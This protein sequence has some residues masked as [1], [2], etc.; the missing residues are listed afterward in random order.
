MIRFNLFYPNRLLQLAISIVLS[1]Y[2]ENCGSKAVKT[3]KA[4]DLERYKNA[5]NRDG[6][7]SQIMYGMKEPPLYAA[8]REG[9]AEKVGILLK[10]IKADFT[11]S[12]EEK[13]DLNYQDTNFPNSVDKASGDTALLKAIRN[14]QEKIA[15][16]LINCVHFKK[17][18]TIANENNKT[19]TPLRLAIANKLDNAAILLIGKLAESNLGVLTQAKSTQDRETPLHLAVKVK[20]HTIAD[21]LID[22][23][24][25]GD[26][27]AIDNKGQTA[28]HIAI[29]HKLTEIVKKLIQRQATESLYIADAEQNT[30]LH[31]AIQRK[32]ETMA[33]TL[34]EKLVKAQA[35]ES[36]YIADA[37]QNTPLHIAIQRKLTNVA[38]LLIDHINA[39][40]LVLV[41]NDKNNKMMPLH[42]AIEKGEYE[43]VK[44]LV[45]KVADNCREKLTTCD[46]KDRNPL[47]MAA[48]YNDIASFESIWNEV[49]KL[50]NPT[51][52]LIKK[53]HRDATVFARA[54]LPKN[55]RLNASILSI[56]STLNTHGKDDTMFDSIL[57]LVKRELKSE[58][59]NKIREEIKQEI[60]HFV[61]FKNKSNDRNTRLKELVDRPTIK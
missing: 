1:S 30:P 37:E 56:D 54:Y 38:R 7:I 24:K 44:L 3:A 34:I 43:V 41:N 57:I 12:E 42:I 11:K 14:K 60:D 13:K 15:E 52:Y 36:L 53:D 10:K 58:D 31:I 48:G 61:P 19:D 20:A 49:S 51:H 55:R 26:L 35:T 46:G 17:S 33:T 47:H 32:F 16:L 2:A 18:L 22:K 21:C 50:G 27:N 39:A 29:Q 8:V 25:E 9:N 5:I 28:L 45:K 40:S 4:A 6:D 23:L 59:W